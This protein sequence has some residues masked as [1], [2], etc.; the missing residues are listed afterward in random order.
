MSLLLLT[1]IFKSVQMQTINYPTNF[2]NQSLMYEILKSK[3]NLFTFIVFLYI[4]RIKTINYC[5]FDN[6]EKFEKR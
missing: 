6:N 2:Q 5:I 3:M 1:N 4:F